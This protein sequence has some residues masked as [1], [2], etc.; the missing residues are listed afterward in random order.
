MEEN[1]VAHDGKLKDELIR[2]KSILEKTT[3]RSVLII[4]EIF[5]STTLKDALELGRIMMKDLSEKGCLALSV[6]F[7]DEL[8]TF[9]EHT[10]SYVAG[11]NKDIPGERSYHI[12]RRA[13]DGI[14]Y[15]EDIARKYH[16]T[17]SDLKER[18]AK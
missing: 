16:L 12:S 15:A 2:L 14:A 7:L 3:N 18:L 4:N 11:I 10:V 9:D 5:S 6:T 13:S 1:A 8:S 17:Y